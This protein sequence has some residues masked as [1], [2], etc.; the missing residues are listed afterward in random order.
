LVAGLLVGLLVGLRNGTFWVVE[1]LRHAQTV[2]QLQGSTRGGCWAELKTP[3]A[4]PGS[5]AHVFGA[6]G[7]RTG[8]AGKHRSKVHPWERLVEFGSWI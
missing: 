8:G 3:F 5:S 4:S 7:L 6:L 2:V 1:I